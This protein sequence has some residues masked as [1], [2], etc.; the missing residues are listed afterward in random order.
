MQEVIK[1]YKCTKCDIEES[2]LKF[3]RKKSFLCASCKVIE[4]DIQEIL[5]NNDILEKEDI[6]KYLVQCG[7]S[8]SPKGIPYKWYTTGKNTLRVSLSVS[9]GSPMLLI[10]D[11]SDNICFTDSSI[12]KHLPREAVLDLKKVIN[13]IEYLWEMEKK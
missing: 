7:F 6:I 10:M 3:E 2:P 12:I 11:K 13:T 9:C 1:L 5:G 8:I 4:N